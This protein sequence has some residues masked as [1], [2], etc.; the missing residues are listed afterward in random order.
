MDADLGLRTGKVIRYMDNLIAQGAIR[1]IVIFMPSSAGLPY[2]GQ[3]E[4]FITRELPVWLRQTFGVH[5]A[6]KRSAITGL[7][8]GG[9]DALCLPLRRPD[10]YG[11]SFSLSGYFGDDIIAA[12]PDRG[13]PMQSVLICGSEDELVATNRTL[14]AALTT[15]HAQFSYRE[16][17]GGHTWRYWS[18]RVVEMLTATNAH[19]TGK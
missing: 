15:R 13:L 19:F 9:T 2:V 7:S 17:A 14:V 4:Q 16:D 6:R 18:H 10:L 11:F 8:M 1:P 12:L 5:A 3:S